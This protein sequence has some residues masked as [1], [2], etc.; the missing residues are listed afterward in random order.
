M[1]SHVATIDD[2]VE[3]KQANIRASQSSPFRYS[4]ISSFAKTPTKN[5]QPQES[6]IPN[7]G[8]TMLCSL[9]AEENTSPVLPDGDLAELI[10][11]DEPSLMKEQ[12][13]EGTTRRSPSTPDAGSTVLNSS[14]A[15]TNTS[16]LVPRRLFSELIGN[17]THSSDANDVEVSPPSQNN[18][19]SFHDETGNSV[20]P[21]FLN[22]RPRING[23]SRLLRDEAA[24]ID[25]MIMH[26]SFYDE[27]ASSPVSIATQW[28]Q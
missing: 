26:P 4:H 15:E 18:R 8:S 14:D 19:P 12:R 23:I 21:P 10:G 6:F 24:P 17:A 20:R 5:S 22:I 27:N 16:P 11:N 2:L 1:S 3:D 25:F 13:P 7:A 28:F 9:G